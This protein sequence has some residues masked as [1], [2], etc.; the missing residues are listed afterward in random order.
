MSVAAKTFAEA[1]AEARY[2]TAELNPVIPPS[3]RGRPSLPL[4]LLKRWEPG[5]ANGAASLVPQGLL[6]GEAKDGG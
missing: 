1:V 4:P 2:R 6:I 3:A 5:E